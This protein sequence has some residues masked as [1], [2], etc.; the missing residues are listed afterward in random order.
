MITSNKIQ[1]NKLILIIGA[2]ISGLSC[3]K[4]FYANKTPF[5]ILEA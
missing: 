2:G 4:L 5:L 3:A 1:T